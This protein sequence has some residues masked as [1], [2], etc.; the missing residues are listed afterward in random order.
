[1]K[2]NKVPIDKYKPENVAYY[3]EFL[4]TVEELDPRRIKFC[5]EKLLKGNEIFN[6]R[7]RRDPETGEV[8][9]MTVDSDFRNTYSIVG[10]SGIDKKSP[11]VS[12]VIHEEKNDATSF[13]EKVAEAIAEGFLRAGD[14]LVMDNAAIHLQG[15]N[16]GLDDWLWE[17]HRIAV[18]PL[19][20]RSPE[21]N[22][23][24]LTW[25]SLVSKLRALPLKTMERHNQHATAKEASRILSD[26]SHKSIRASYRQCGYL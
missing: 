26:M 22:P 8:P 12:F 3:R 9:E 10:F 16:D 23:I 1:M 25:R 2:G 15:E 13:F 11:P 17:N 18:L 14:V 4:Q 6:K 21:L 5:D 7:G 24:E 20:T 19:P